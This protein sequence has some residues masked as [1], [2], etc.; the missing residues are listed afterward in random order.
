[1][2]DAEKCAFCGARLKRGEKRICRRCA[3]LMPRVVAVAERV[4]KRNPNGGLWKDR[5]RRKC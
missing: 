1:M 4:A 3:A 5:R 2:T